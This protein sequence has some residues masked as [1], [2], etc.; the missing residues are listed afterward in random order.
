M[1]FSSVTLLYPTLDKSGKI[2]GLRYAE[3]TVPLV[4]AVQEQQ[5]MIDQLNLIVGKQQ[6]QIDELEKL[7]LALG[8]KTSILK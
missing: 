4:K 5:V 8:S 1:L 6:E 3:F 2:M 7:V